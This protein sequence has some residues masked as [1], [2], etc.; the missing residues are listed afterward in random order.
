MPTYTVIDKTTGKE[1]KK[2]KEGKDG[3]QTVE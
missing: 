3:V 1:D 2:E